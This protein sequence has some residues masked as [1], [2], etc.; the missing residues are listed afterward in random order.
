[1]YFT[2]IKCITYYTTLSI[3]IGTHGQT[4]I[5]SKAKL[6]MNIYEPYIQN[7][8][9]LINNHTKKLLDFCEIS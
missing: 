8:F 7:A 3:Y 2:Q 9:I 4:D 1:M 5:M 6:R